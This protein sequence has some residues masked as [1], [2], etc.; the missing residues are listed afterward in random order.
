MRKRSNIAQLR[1]GWGEDLP[2]IKGKNG[3]KK[4]RDGRQGLL[5]MLY[6]REGK[7]ATPWE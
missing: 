7:N 6:S 4:R 2:E 3:W 1:D 5:G